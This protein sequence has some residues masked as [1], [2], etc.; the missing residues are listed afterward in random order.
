ML[1]SLLHKQIEK[2]FDIACTLIDVMAYVPP[3]SLSQRSN[4]DSGPRDYLNRF[5]QLISTLRG[6]QSRYLP[7][8][9]NKVNEVLPSHSLPLSLSRNL[10]ANAA[11][12]SN[13]RLEDVYES[14]GGSA[15]Q[16]ATPYDSPPSHG[17]PAS[18]LSMRPAQHLPSSQYSSYSGHYDNAS[19]QVAGGASDYSMFQTPIGYAELSHAGVT[20]QAQA[21]QGNVASVYSGQVQQM[22]GVTRA[23]G[24]GE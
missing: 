15:S 1:I 20:Q 17:P 4:F 11:S 23:G 7:L 19:S 9:V 22:G 18:G 2:L 13:T 8:I 10:Q 6:G 21:S 5:I 14:S 3:Q 12:G 16:E 24:Y